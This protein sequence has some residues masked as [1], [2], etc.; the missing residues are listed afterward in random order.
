MANAVHV[1]CMVDNG[2]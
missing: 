1:L 2:M